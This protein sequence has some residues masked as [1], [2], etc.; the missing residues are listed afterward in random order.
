MK[1]IFSSWMFIMCCLT[2]LAQQPATNAVSRFESPDHIYHIES[3]ALFFIDSTGN[4]PLKKVADQNFQ[5][6]ESFALRKSIPRSLLLKTIY[7]KFS[8]ENSSTLPR[9]FY[10]FPGMY[11][12]DLKLYRINQQGIP[13]PENKSIL[14][15]GCI[16]LTTQPGQCSDF[17]VKMRWSRND[18]NRINAKLI[19][20]AYLDNFKLQLSN[21]VYDRN[22]AGF[23]LSGILVMMILFTLVNFFISGKMEFLYNCLYSTCMFLMVF[24]YAYLNNDPGRFNAFFQS[25]FAFFLLMTGT[26][27]YIQFTRFFLDTFT[28]HALL[29]KIFRFEI[30]IIGATLVFYT[31]IHYFTPYV[32]LE[33]Y[34]ETSLK[35]AV[36][37]IGI[38]YVVIGMANKNR[39]MNYLAIGNALQ[40]QFSGISLIFILFGIKATNIF[41][42]A[43]FYFEIGIVISVFFF[44]L[45]LM[46]KNRSE[47]IDRIREKEALKMD[48]E[49]KE[50]ETKLAILHAQQ[51]ER[52]RISA[53]MHDDLGAGMTTIRLYSELA[54]N[55]MGNQS[56]PE[57]DKIS[58][59]ADELL[60]KMNA[61]IWSMTTSNDSLGNTVAYIRSYAREYFEN[62]GIECH[63]SLPERIPEI[64]VSGEIR[65]NIFLVVKEALNNIVKHAQA[66]RVDISLNKEPLGLSLTIKDNGKG[67]DFDHIRNFG[68]G[69][70]NMKKRMEDLGIEFS[71]SND[72][73]TLIRLYREIIL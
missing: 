68:N 37:L 44:L 47:L 35:I 30:W 42:S 23:V 10:F 7:L 57:I 18:Y 64:E 46:Y 52:N 50:F 53:D 9:S 26:I 69:L 6:L 5:P 62:T 29:D 32:K 58:A 14:K 25:Y 1:K 55:K 38:L 22:S 28:K 19:D 73:G 8:I 12:S 34:I 2:C 61:I 51:A 65:R 45:G 31:L 20:P 56:L 33:G 54:K 39:L 21:S 11:Y 13:V 27:F 24:L 71:I 60:I 41:N 66:S 59:S 36:L 3:S 4:L 67:I 40:I 16:Y 43:L 49:K 72:N 17:M 63:I 48:A 70:K 15:S